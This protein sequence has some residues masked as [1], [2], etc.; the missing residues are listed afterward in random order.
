MRIIILGLFVTAMAFFG[1]ARWIDRKPQEVASVSPSIV[2]IVCGI[3]VMVLD[4]GLTMIY[5]LWRLFA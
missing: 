4:I 5:A 2:P 1:W 3:V